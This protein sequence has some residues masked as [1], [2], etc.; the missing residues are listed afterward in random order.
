MPF[1]RLGTHSRTPGTMTMKTTD[2]VDQIR[3]AL[4][5]AS[6]FVWTSP[7]PPTELTEVADRLERD[8]VNVVLAASH[9]YA[10]T[11][12]WVQAWRRD[13]SERRVSAFCAAVAAVV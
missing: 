13:L 4:A 11:D 5:E 3:K 1:E 2:R 10:A 9:R 6:E 8:Q 12:S 7:A